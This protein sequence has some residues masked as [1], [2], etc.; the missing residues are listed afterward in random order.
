MQLF[1]LF[2]DL[3]GRA[4]VV[5]GGG[6]IAERKIHLL[7]S[8]G[9]NVTVVAKAISPTLQDWEAQ[10][11][12]WVRLGAF[13]ESD[14]DGAWL[15]VAATDNIQLNTAIAAHAT[16][17]KL[18]AN[19]VDNASLSSFQVPAI[20][21]RSPLVV[22]ISSSGAAPM[23]A[24]RVRAQIETMV[25]HSIGAI[26]E[27][28]QRYRGH[29]KEALPL[30]GPRRAFYDWLI[31]GPVGKALKAQQPK[32][33]QSL[34]EDALGQKQTPPKGEVILVGAGPGDPGL[35]TLH[36]LRALNQADV[37]L[38]DRLVD[39]A[40]L[41]LARRDATQIHVGKEVGEN[42][43]ATQQRIHHLMLEHAKQGQTV[44]RLKGGDAFIFGRGGEELQFL[45]QHS[46]AYQV[47][48]G[49]TAALACAAYS[50]IPLTHRQYAQSVQFVTAHRKDDTDI[51]E[52]AGL[53]DNS[54]T[55]V[56][57]MGLKQ[58]TSFNQML[59]AHGRAANTPCAIIENGSRPNQRT[60][61]TRL[62]QAQHY[63][64]Q[65]TFSSPSLLI[66]G[67]VAALAKQLHWYGEIID[68]YPDADTPSL[69][70]LNVEL[71]PELSA[72]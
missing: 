20:V 36:A 6:E 68:E 28:A 22:A 8:A 37:I 27:L 51:A 7:T 11:R 12:I 61:L 47:V 59:I 44:V 70:Q 10:N 58:L 13:Q 18:F 21:D 24:R 39:P 64:S 57:Y 48:P 38:Y 9:A 69:S 5:V 52:W 56:V 40:I 63:A 50:G 62:D 53:C 16:S 60:L 42:H 35:L 54:Q 2:A 15:V 34:L 29:I 4:V 31:D 30:L 17:R 55:L 1:P 46:I 25:D 65:Y 67:P 43:H 41:E 49:I 72:A 19:V 71:L 45:R 26:A 66:V 14:L 32:Q 3:Q 33:A 23:V